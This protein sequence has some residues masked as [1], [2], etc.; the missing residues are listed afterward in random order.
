MEKQTILL[1][2][3]EE[4]LLSLWTL[5][6]ENAGYAV[7][8]ARSGEEAMAVFNASSPQLVITDLRME[9]MDGMALYQAIREINT[10]VP[11]LIITAH[12]SIPEAVDATQKG[13]FAFLTKPI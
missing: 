2:D 3:D 13:V 11:V 1:V 5:R 7:L 4:D 10:T 9:K 12:G 6:L 8:T